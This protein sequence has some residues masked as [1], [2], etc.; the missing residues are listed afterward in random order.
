MA[1]E[2]FREPVHGHNYTVGA[3]IGGAEGLQADGYVVDFGDVKKALRQVVGP[4]NSRTLLPCKSDVMQIRLREEHYEVSCQGAHI[5]L[6]KGDCVMLPI[7]H[8]TAEE[9]AEYI[10]REVLKLVGEQLRARGCSWLEIK[11]AE[12]PG[13]A[14]VCSLSVS[15]TVSE[16]RRRAPRPC[17]S[18]VSSDG[19]QGEQGFKLLLST[20]PEAVRKELEKTPARAYKA[21]REM[22]SGLFMDPKEVV[23]DAIFEV[24]GA[25][26]LVVV[27]NIPFHSMCEHHLLPFSG[28]ASIAYFPNE[29]VLGLSKFARVLEV[30]ARRLQLQE[31]LG[32]QVAEFLNELLQPKACMHTVCNDVEYMLNLCFAQYPLRTLQRI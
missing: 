19:E 13:Q 22:T 7:V 10:G 2:G 11:V 27:H 32:L 21:F 23:G 16:G 6:P 3:R 30:F 15:G 29:R 9:I 1:Y 20:L 5:V 24:K 8:T 18:P 17:M 12:R 28:T 4:L 31:R 25:H 14:G 26:D